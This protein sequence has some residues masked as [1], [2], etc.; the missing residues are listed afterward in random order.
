MR[1]LVVLLMVLVCV[2]ATFG[3]DFPTPKND[4]FSKTKDARPDTENFSGRQPTSIEKRRR[5][6]VGVQ[7]TSLMRDGDGDR[8][9]FGGRVGYDFAT[10]GQGKYVA[11]AEAEINFLPGDRRVDFSAV[12]IGS[13][14]DGRVLQGLFGV[15]AGR[16]FDKFGVFLKARPGFV[17][18]S[19]GKQNISGTTSD[20]RLS[21]DPETNAAF[22][23]GGVLEFYPTKRIT[24][25]FDAGDTII[26]FG[27]R[28]ATGF[29]FFNQQFIPLRLPS[30]YKHTFQFSAGIGFR[31]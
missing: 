10:F 1:G 22:D 3:Q 27:R 5:F 23:V 7:F 15:K 21:Q 19:R 11:T 18:Y 14:R 30:Q 17:Q 26:R 12:G 24:T 2:F 16:K 9:G 6:E 20:L 29:D 4:L 28:S 31:F 8:N 25:R 13:R